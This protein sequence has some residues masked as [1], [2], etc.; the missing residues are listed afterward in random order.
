[1]KYTTN[2]IADMLQRVIFGWLLVYGVMKLGLWF[3]TG[4]F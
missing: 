3:T 2:M 4:H 1:M